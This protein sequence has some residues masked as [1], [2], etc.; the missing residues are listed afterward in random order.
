MEARRKGRRRGR[1]EDFME[2]ERGFRQHRMR[3]YN[4]TVRFRKGLLGH[5]F[6][7][8]GCHKLEG[9]TFFFEEG[10]FVLGIEL[11]ASQLLG[12]GS[13]TQATP[14]S[15][16]GILLTFIFLGLAKTPTC[17]VKII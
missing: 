8:S 6:V 17:T 16:K 4:S 11:R 9:S 15:R 3:L 7:P 12:K 2:W 10:R 1:G 5:R 13:I 14:Q